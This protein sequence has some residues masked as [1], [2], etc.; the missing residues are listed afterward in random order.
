MGHRGLQPDQA[1][2]PL[3]GCV[4]VAD[5]PSGSVAASASNAVGLIEMRIM[6]II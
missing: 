2:A 5:E 3:V 1:F 4:L 6:G